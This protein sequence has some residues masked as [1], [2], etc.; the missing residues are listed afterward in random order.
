MQEKPLLV[1]G[2]DPGT[3]IGYAVLDL[4]GN[5]IKIDS[6]KHITLSSLISGIT[7]IGKVILVGTDKKAVPGFVKKFAVKGGLRN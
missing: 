7:A 4:D 2:I 3:T 5:L 6:S 1:V